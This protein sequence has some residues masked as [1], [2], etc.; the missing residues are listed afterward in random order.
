MRALRFLKNGTTPLVDHFVHEVY[1]IALLVVLLVLLGELLDHLV[2]ELAEGF[3]L[4]FTCLTA[5]VQ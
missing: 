2:D 3:R 1:E 4:V 5:L